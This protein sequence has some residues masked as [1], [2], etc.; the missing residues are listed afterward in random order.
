MSVG[1]DRRA[2]LEL[3]DA[4]ARLGRMQTAL[5]S[6]PAKPNAAVLA[7]DLDLGDVAID[8]VK[9][10]DLDNGFERLVLAEWRAHDFAFCAFRIRS[11]RRSH[12]L[13]FEQRPCA[14]SIGFATGFT[15]GD[16]P[17]YWQS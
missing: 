17:L 9:A 6:E 8:V 10:N 1:C 16:G 15:I 14:E 13:R 3:V 11:W 4:D 7:A 5:E 2:Q 12:A